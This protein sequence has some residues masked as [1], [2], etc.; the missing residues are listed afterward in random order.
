MS[1]EKK[2][3]VGSSYKRKEDM[4]L[5]TGR[6]TFMDDIALP[7]MKH[8][9]ILRSPYAHAR[10]LGVDVSEALKASGVIGVIIGEDV[11][12]ESKP[13]PC[14]VTI[15]TKYYTCAVD[16]VRFVGEPVAVVVADNRYLAEDALDLIEVD[17]EPLEAIV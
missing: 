3:W 7:N 14:G 9:A 2:K 15:P 17:Y 4:R 12:K 1:G 10:I 16:K 5:L 8:A 11:K 13:Y 6:G